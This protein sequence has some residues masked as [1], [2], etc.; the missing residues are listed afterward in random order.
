M[1]SELSTT[2]GQVTKEKAAFGVVLLQMGGPA[3]L[4]EVEPFLANLFSDRDLVQ[5]P[6]GRFYQNFLARKIAARRAPMVSL[7]YAEIGGGSPVHEQTIA[8]VQALAAALPRTIPVRHV[9]RYCE[10][11]AKTVLEELRNS[12]IDRVVALSMYPQR[13]RAT[14]TSSLSDLEGEAQILRMAVRAVSE[15][16]TE[17]GFIRAW[18]DLLRQ[19]L[20]RWASS[21]SNIHVLF[22]A[23]AVPTSYTRR[24]DPYVGQ[25]RAT[26][27]A[28]QN[29][30]PDL[31]PSSLA[32]QG[33]VGPMK[34]HRPS[35]REA[36]AACV[37]NNC[38]VLCM[39]PLSFTCEHLETL[40]EL[41]VEAK[42]V[43]RE[44]GIPNFQRLPTVACHPLFIAELARLTL[45]AAGDWA[46]E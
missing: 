24:G 40:H 17:P 36:V 4:A 37:R 6:L 44:A 8:Q 33:Q 26:M 32:F 13:S 1:Q 31:P 21:P 14:T 46:G 43:A 30:V 41:D 11:R 39:V 45:A 10:P 9:F 5:L 25:V 2:P 7:K 23:H 20:Q 22:V 12:G 35:V 38:E 29:A 42:E 15:Y 19:G 16:P 28:I 3:N 34:W 27:Q 18:A